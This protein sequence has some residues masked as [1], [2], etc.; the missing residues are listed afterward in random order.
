MTKTILP[1]SFFFGANNMNGYCSL[2]KDVYNPFEKGNHIIIKGGPGTGKSTIMKKV[3]EKLEK[4]GYYIERGYCS[5]DPDSLDIVIAPEI[6]FSILDGTAPHTIDPTVPGVSEHIIDLST[7]WDK[8]YLELHRN[9]IFDLIKSNS[10]L[11]KKVASFQSVAAQIETQSVLLCNNFIDKAK[12]E[13]YAKRAC[14]RHIPKKSA[15][16]KGKLNKRFLSA[17]TPDGII[18]LQDTIVALSEKII[19]IKDE[20]SIISPA[21]TEY[22]SNYAVNMGYDIYACYC[23]LFPTFKIEHVII[24]ELKIAFFTENSY[25]H[26]IDDESITV[27]ASRFYNKESFKLNKEKLAFQKKA[28]KELIDEA[29][30][31]LSLAL[32]IHDKLEDYYIKATDF[33]V[34]EEKAAEII[35]QV[36]K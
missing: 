10:A 18:T 15:N 30:K 20:F 9:E 19:T 31:N 24:P 17:V 6:N 8:S 26:P 21:I 2:Y 27:N 32:K 22:I 3:A 28:K 14:I 25:H 16:K 5:A 34:V 23:P 12:A 13:R 33:N 1:V 29:V 11:H 35:K 7:A 4:D 36:N